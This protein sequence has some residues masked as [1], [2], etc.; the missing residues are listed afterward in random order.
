MERTGTVYHLFCLLTKQSHEAQHA[1]YLMHVRDLRLP[2]E[3]VVSP[4]HI[5]L[6]GLRLMTMHATEITKRISKDWTLASDTIKKAQMQ[7]KQQHESLMEQTPQQTGWTQQ[8]ETLDKYILK[9][10]AGRC[11]T[12]FC[13]YNPIVCCKQVLLTQ[14]IMMIQGPA[15]PP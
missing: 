4:P 2:T 15:P 9:T 5:P 7:Q 6:N 12:H 13:L 3:A 14:L 1:F 8:P 10:R 11:R